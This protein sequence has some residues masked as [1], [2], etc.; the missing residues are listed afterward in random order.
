M[1]QF[2]H[3][4]FQDTLDTAMKNHTQERL[5]YQRKLRS[6]VQDQMLH[7]WSSDGGLRD[8]QFQLN[9]SHYDWDLE[10]FRELHRLDPGHIQVEMHVDREPRYVLSKIQSIKGE[11][12]PPEKWDD[13]ARDDEEISKAVCKIKFNK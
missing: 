13:I 2:P 9:A 11:R 1:D 4:L 7:A 8:L 12:L 3:S 6:R 5:E 10:V